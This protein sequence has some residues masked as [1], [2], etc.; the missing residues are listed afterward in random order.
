MYLKSLEYAKP[1]SHAPDTSKVAAL[2][3][4]DSVKTSALSQL[5]VPPNMIVSSTLIG[6]YDDVECLLPEKTSMMSFQCSNPS[7]HSSSKTSCPSWITSRR[8]GLDSLLEVQD[9][10]LLTSPSRCGMPSR[11]PLPALHALPTPWKP[12]TM[13]SIR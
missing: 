10:W 8:P 12:I 6:V 1:H 13:L 9:A 7:L 11:D 2:K 4:V 5:T 3:K